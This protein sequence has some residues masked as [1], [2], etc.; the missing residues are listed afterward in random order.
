MPGR[1]LSP[2]AVPRLVEE[3][4]ER[5]QAALAWRHGHDPA[6]DPALPG[7]PDVKKPVARALVHP[8]GRHDRERMLLQPTVASRGARA[9]W[10]SS[11]AV[12]ITPLT[13]LR[14]SC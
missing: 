4:G 11:A 6:C 13:S 2:D 1:E 12:T 5:P 14:A 3:G 10:S 9:A 8:G 7:H